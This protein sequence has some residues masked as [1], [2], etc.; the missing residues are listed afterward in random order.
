MKK[1]SGKTKWL[2]SLLTLGFILLLCLLVMEVGGRALFSG[3]DGGSP[4]SLFYQRESQSVQPR[5]FLFSFTDPLLGWGRSPAFKEY[6]S[7]DV[8]S[9]ERVK[10]F[11]VGQS[12]RGVKRVVGLGGST[13]DHNVQPRNWMYYLA[14]GCT[15][16]R[17]K[18]QSLNGGIM[19]YSTTQDFLKLVRD[20]IP[21]KPDLVISLSGVNDF[22]LNA[23][24]GRTFVNTHHAEIE[25]ALRKNEWEIGRAHV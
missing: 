16:R 25:S 9:E 14:E 13:T 5:S 15:E 1:Y 6:F 24:T 22:S 3:R 12:L 8:P 11:E 4:Y 19:G 23:L 21:L 17:E 7:D 18:C 20:V 10:G 2:F